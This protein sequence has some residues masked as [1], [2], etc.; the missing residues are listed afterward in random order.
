MLK[1]INR[2]FWRG[3]I[4]VMPITLSIYLFLVILN[5]AENLFGNLIKQLV[6]PSLYIPGLGIVIT[7][8]LMVVVGILVSNFITGSVINFFINQFEKVP[9]IKAIYNPLRD[10]ISL[11]GGAGPDSMKKVVL[12][13]L[14]SLGVQ[15]IGLVTREE[16]D[17]MPAGTFTEDKIAVYIP[18]SYMLGGFTA[19]VDR[20][21]VKELDIPVEKAIKLAIT[22]WI[23]ADKNVI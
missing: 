11:F 3:L 10:L 8:I 14:G 22:G 17:D 23:K 18:M 5:Q 7:I 16:F 1:I 2:L 12:V 6:G 21:Q 9:F 4:V 13:N 20:S 19:I 15:S